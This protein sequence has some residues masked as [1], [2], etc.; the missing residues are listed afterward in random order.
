MNDNILKEDFQLFFSSFHFI[1][2]PPI[3]STQSLPSLDRS[4][5]KCCD[6][7]PVKNAISFNKKHNCSLVKLQRRIYGANLALQHFIRT[8]WVFENECFL[9]LHDDIKQTDLKSFR[10]D[11][12]VTADV[13]EYFLDC[14]L[15]AR[16]YLLHE[17]D[18]DLPRARR[19]YRR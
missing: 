2:L 17:K 14:M 15:G 5:C 10:Y 7:I 9:K 13:R 18:E 6:I 1:S 4:N 16:R 11:N 12:F 3:S 8:H 19:N